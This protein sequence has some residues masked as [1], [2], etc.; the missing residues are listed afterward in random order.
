MRSDWF[1]LKRLGRK[2]IKRI[3]PL[4]RQINR[5]RGYRLHDAWAK[6]PWRPMGGDSG[7]HNYGAWVV[8]EGTIMADS[9]VYSAG[10]GLDVSFDEQLISVYGC[11][12]FGFDP[13]P[14][15]VDFVAGRSLPA[16]FKF[17]PVGL[18]AVDGESAFSA[19]TK[20][21]GS[22]WK[23]GDAD[24]GTAERMAVRR[25]A[26]LMR[27]MGHDHIDLLKLDIEGYEHEVIADVVA[28]GVR[29][30][31]ILVEFHHYQLRDAASTMRSVETLRDAGYDLF[32]VSDL[33]TDYGFVLRAAS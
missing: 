21:I 10:V 27:E 11:D 24:S 17:F 32:W 14:A 20:A 7:P 9:I 31:C 3:P 28:S 2:A 25:V 16:Q 4:Y 33:G 18:A 12:V 1:V 15:A 5:W 19:S 13:S 8:P 26:S 22:F 6:L 30:N 23:A 29:P